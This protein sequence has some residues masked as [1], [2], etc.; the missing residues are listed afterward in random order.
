MERKQIAKDVPPWWEFFK[1]RINVREALEPYS[2]AGDALTDEFK[3][4]II[5]HYRRERYIEEV[6]KAKG[7]AA[8]A[9]K[10]MQEQLAAEERER[11][12]ALALLEEFE[13][14]LKLSKGKSG[15]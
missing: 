11:V 7:A 13:E 15:K 4:T 2:A 14:G 10:Q 6:W 3:T 9:F 8:V 5:E 12:T 1:G